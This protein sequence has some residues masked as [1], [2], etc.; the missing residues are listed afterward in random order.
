MSLSLL[1]GLRRQ[2]NTW[3]FD[4]RAVKVD[5]DNLS[6]A[7]LGKTVATARVK[8]GRIEIEWLDPTW[9]MWKDLQDAPEFK[10]LIEDNN[11]RLARA[12][13]NVKGGGKGKSKE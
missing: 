4:R 6:L 12:A 10:K 1:L 11:E 3:G 8:G 2:L 5:D 13:E 7:V 9:G